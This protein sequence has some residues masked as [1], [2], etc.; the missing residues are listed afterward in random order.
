VDDPGGDSTRERLNV[1]MGVQTRVRVGLVGCGVISGIYLQNAK[2]FPILDVVACADLV[3]QR[4][5][6]RAAEYGISRTAS[7]ADLLADPEIE[8]V[9][10][11]TVPAAHAEI[12][13]AAVAAGKSVYNEKPLTISLEDGRRLVDLAAA[14]GVRVGCAPD[15]FLGAGLQTCRAL[16][17]QGAIGEPV[18]ATASMLCHGHESWHPD[19]SFYYQ[20]GGGPL[21]D[22]GPYYLTALVSLLG[23][24]RRVTGSARASF[25]QRTITS[26][27]RTGETIDVRVP[28]HTAAVLD[29]ADG[30][31]ATF[32]ASFDVWARETRIEI[33]GSDG[34]LGVP[35]PNSFG[36]PVLLRRPGTADWEET[37][38]N[39][40]Y[41][42][43]SRGL[44]VAD[45]AAAIRESRPHRASGDLA[46]H[47]LETMHAVHCAS[48][49]GRH[50]EL[51]SRVERPAPLPL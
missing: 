38:L 6:A 28:T 34:T 33:Y 41:A 46:L 45:M 50:V 24:I 3:P 31:I 20:P 26:K 23:P 2:R 35:D 9:L 4:A 29:F 19:P 27:P 16:I 10:N 7:V 30:A 21:F 17:D 49:E 39:R 47:V 11:L 1:S 37:P 51:T 40:D 8:L 25:A 43:N 15:T 44:G 36:G 48:D 13:F 18:A 42:D 5:A 22:M 14:K 12:A 32:V